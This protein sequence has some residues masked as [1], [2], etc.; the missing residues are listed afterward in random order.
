MSSLSQEKPL[1]AARRK[2]D[3]ILVVLSYPPSRVYIDPDSSVEYL[4]PVR[5]L[6]DIF[7]ARE[8]PDVIDVAVKANGVDRYVFGCVYTHAEGR[9]H[10]PQRFPAQLVSGER[11]SLSGLPSKPFYFPRAASKM[12]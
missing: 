1:E 8:L 7:L 10:D 5:I 2:Q 4:Y 11:P 9:G 12:Q 3:D 6:A